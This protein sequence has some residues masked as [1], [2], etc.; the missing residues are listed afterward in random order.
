MG[1]DIMWLSEPMMLLGSMA[2]V[3]LNVVF[4]SWFVLLLLVFASR[5]T[6]YLARSFLPLALRTDMARRGRAT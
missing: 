3:Y 2:G 6:T 1:Y 4:P 5:G